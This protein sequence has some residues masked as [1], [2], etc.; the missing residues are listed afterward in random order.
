MKQ[1]RVRSV[2][3]FLFTLGAAA[4]LN[5]AAPMRVQD[6]WLAW[7][8][9]W[10]ALGDAS[11]R[12]L[13][14]VP[15]GNAARMI[16]VAAGKVQSETRVVS[17][18]VARPVSREGCTGTEQARWSTDEQRLFTMSDMKCG[19]NMRRKVT[20]VMAMKTGSEWLSVQ[21][22][23]T[24]GPGVA[25]T[26][27]YVP[28]SPKDVPQEVAALLQDNRLASETA[29]YA[30]SQAVDLSDVAEASRAVDEQVVVDW[31]TELAQPF[32]LTGEK[33]IGLA[34]AGVPATVLEVLVAVSNPQHF[35]V[36]NEARQ[37]PDPYWGRGGGRIYD[38]CWGFARGGRFYSPFAIGY[39][40]G[41]DDDYYRYG[42]S[43]YGYGYRCGYT[44]WGYDPWGWYPAG[45]TVI[46]VRGSDEDNN[47][48]VTRDGYKGS[49]SKGKARPRTGSTDHP[50]SPPPTTTTSRPTVSSGGYGTGSSS[51][52]GGSSGTSTG[53][54]AK[55]KDK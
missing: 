7:Q 41:Y 11:D 6:G 49:T 26:L 37:D 54:T 32:E 55:P 12:M 10:R 44:P 27:H 33:L 24:R 50:T 3:L 13:C 42:N 28:V 38:P 29:R 25:R 47:A 48:Q 5:A 17:D 16:E 20:G 1:W 53:R 15:D 45:T 40:W 19:E 46:V 9:C 35:A 43:R 22:V 31:L 36:R 14:I 30:A 8:G 2:G 39:G 18:A 4:S 23:A 34:N 52:G 51:S 21:A